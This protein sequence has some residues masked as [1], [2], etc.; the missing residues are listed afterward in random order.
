MSQSLVRILEEKTIAEPEHA[1]AAWMFLSELSAFLNVQFIYYKTKNFKI[2]PSKVSKIW[3][4]SNLDFGSSNPII[5]YM[6][7][8]LANKAEMLDETTCAN[9]KRS[10]QEAFILY[11]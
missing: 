10:F 9:L 3:L 7:K 11:K 4:S 1:N 2:D 5:N 8:I 6:L